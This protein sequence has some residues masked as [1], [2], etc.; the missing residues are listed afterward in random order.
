MTRLFHFKSLGIVLLL[1]SLELGT[2]A[3]AQVPHHQERIRKTTRDILNRPEFGLFPRLK[4]GEPA[5]GGASS[6]HRSGVP[7]LKSS[8]GGVPEPGNF[9]RQGQVNRARR[10]GPAAKKADAQ[11]GGPNRFPPDIPGEKRGANGNPLNAQDA[12]GNEDLFP[13]AGKLNGVENPDLNINP[14]ERPNQDDLNNANPQANNNPPNKRPGNQGNPARANEKPQQEA[15]PDNP[16]AGNPQPA[17]DAAP[18]NNNEALP[19]PRPRESTMSEQNESGS[20]RAGEASEFAQVVGTLFHAMAWTILAVICGLIVWLIGK[21][22]LEFERPTAF[23]PGGAT[24]GSALDLEPSRAP[25][26]LPA[27]VYVTQARKLAEQGLFREAVVQLLMGAMSRVERAGWIRFRQGMTVRDYLRGVQ[28]HPAAHQGMRSIVRV[29]EP[30]T[31]GRREPTQEH[32]DK[33]LKGY[34]T[35]FGLD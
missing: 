25:G 17:G 35:G 11:K 13:E 31:F 26:D 2:L 10:G 8:T 4:P 20:R 23:V 9:G 16:K 21:A 33:S 14:Q 30:L 32:F 18:Q 7:R 3:V 27:D 34:E 6:P 5:R 12:L 15:G 19:A 24:L 28:Q 29:F 1:G 22:I